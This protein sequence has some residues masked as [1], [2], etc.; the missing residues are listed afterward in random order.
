MAAVDELEHYYDRR[1]AE[2][3]E[4]ITTGMSAEAV[5]AWER[6]LAALG[7]VLAALPG[8][9]TLDV[10]C[11]TALFTQYLRGQVVALDRSAA[12]L[13]RART[14]VP[15]AWRVQAAVPALPFA[16][17][18]FDRIVTSHF[19]GHLVE[20]KRLAFLTEAR[21]LAS[22]LVVIDTAAS[23]GA[24]ADGWEE[25]VVG[26]GF[27]YTIYKRRFSP[28]RLM[29]ELADDEHD[30]ESLFAGQFFVAVRA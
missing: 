27:R 15:G 16:S 3:D 26:D 11:G 8:G 10:A 30:S 5:A 20:S 24:P 12:M 9:R 25:R 17:M 21:R 22:E 4:T 2:Y 23:V 7:R 13:E 6:E 19:Y 18:A 28:Q 1:A 29:R 14:R